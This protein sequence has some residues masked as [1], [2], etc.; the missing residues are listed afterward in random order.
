MLDVLLFQEDEA[1][2][3]YLAGGGGNDAVT[4]AATAMADMPLLSYAPFGNMAMAVGT[5][6]CCCDEEEAV[7]SR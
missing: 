6:I 7:V 1:V 3:E 4:E 2:A 5:K